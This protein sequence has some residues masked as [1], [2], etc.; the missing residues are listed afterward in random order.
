MDPRDFATLRRSMRKQAPE[1]AETDDEGIAFGDRQYSTIVPPVLRYVRDQ[2]RRMGTLEG[3]VTVFAD[4][5]R[6]RLRVP[7]PAR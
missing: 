4:L 7:S 1:E 3:R 5:M 2:A 6:D